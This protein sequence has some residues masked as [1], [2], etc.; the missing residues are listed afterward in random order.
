MRITLV[1][2]LLGLLARAHYWLL[3]E[4]AL[5]TLAIAFHW[6]LLGFRY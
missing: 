4:T 2:I 6:N 3:T 5:L 1:A